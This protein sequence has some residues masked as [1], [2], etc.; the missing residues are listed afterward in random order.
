MVSSTCV[1]RSQPLRHNQTTTTTIEM[2]VIRSTRLPNLQWRRQDLAR[3]GVQKGRGNNISH[4]HKMTQNTEKPLSFHQQH[5]ILIAFH[6]C[7]TQNP[8]DI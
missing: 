6:N 7:G 4:A 5:E 1:I 8:K 3:G 2:I